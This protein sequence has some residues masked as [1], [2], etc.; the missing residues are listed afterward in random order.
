[1]FEAILSHVSEGEKSRIL[2]SLFNA[3]SFESFMTECVTFVSGQ[4]ARLVAD[5]SR[6]RLEANKRF[7]SVSKLAAHAKRTSSSV[8]RA[9]LEAVEVFKNEFRENPTL[10]KWNILENHAKHCITV[11]HEM[12][13]GGSFAEE[14][15]LVAHE[16]LQ[17]EIAK[18]AEALVK[19]IGK[20]NTE[21]TDKVSEE[22]VHEHDKFVKALERGFKIEVHH[23]EP[24]NEG[25]FIYMDEENNSEFS[26]QL[27]TMTDRLDKITDKHG[28]LLL[29]QGTIDDIVW[30]SYPNG[31]AK[32]LFVKADLSGVAPDDE[33]DDMDGEQKK[34]KKLQNKDGDKDI[35]T[36]ERLFRAAREMESADELKAHLAA[37]KAA[38]DHETL[39]ALGQ[40]ADEVGTDVEGDPQPV[41]SEDVEADHG[42]EWGEPLDNPACPMC[43]GPGMPLGHMGSR[44]FFRC[45]NC[46]HDFSHAEPGSGGEEKTDSTPEPKDESKKTPRTT[47]TSKPSKIGKAPAMKPV[48]KVKPDSES[49]PVVNQDGGEV[50]MFRKYR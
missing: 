47:K 12:Q 42:D 2:K 16:S 7:E 4:P 8:M 44:M 25:V 35:Q 13:N 11:L 45:R 29:R 6:L 10:G 21:K 37:M 48:K 1:M 36:E 20:S 49:T 43:E 33:L 32:W 5:L 39:Q 30:G 15:A 14:T 40:A 3:K 24:V 17:E 41:D 34:G 50:K 26:S 31:L 23:F 22:D 28:Y 27:K 38:G 19:Q 46:G 18:D 9:Y